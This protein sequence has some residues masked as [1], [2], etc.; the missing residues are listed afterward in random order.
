M[1]TAR[2]NKTGSPSGSPPEP[3]RPDLPHGPSADDRPHS[4]EAEESQNP[5]WRSIPV[6]LAAWHTLI[7][8]TATLVVFIAGYMLLSR[9]VDEQESHLIQQ[10]LHQFR[11]QYDRDGLR[12]VH[13]MCQQRLL[14]TSRTYFVRLLNDSGEQL[15]QRDPQDW[16]G[17][18]LD[19]LPANP[20]PEL[21]WNEV[22]GP[23]DLLLRVASQRTKD[24]VTL[25]VGK[26]LELRDEILGRFR[27][28]WIGIGLFLGAVGAAGGIYAT[29]RAL[30]PVA[31]LTANAQAIMDTGDFSSR[32]KSARTRDELDELVGCF[33][34]MLEKIERL[35][36]GMR[37][38]LD[39][40]AHDLRTPMTRLRHNALRAVEGNLDQPQCIHALGDCLEESDR[41][42]TLLSN[43]M[44]IAEAE[45]GA[46]SFKRQELSLHPLGLKILDLYSDLAEEKQVALHVH[47]PEEL[48]VD[49]EEIRLFRAIANLVDN[50]LKYSGPGGSVRL[51]GSLRSGTVHIEVADQGCGIPQDELPRIWERLYRVDR[52]RDLKGL[53]LGL[54]LVKAIVEAHGG[55]V[56]VVSEF[57][58]GSRFLLQF[59]AASRLAPK[60]AA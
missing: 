49:G 31:Q 25:Q 48:R 12:G 9:W 26:T 14:R 47:L 38:A 27:T 44:D 21:R 43:L 10:R 3:K 36:A 39:N 7:Y 16:D 34:G 50:A 18:P 58:K 54:S 60:P 19:S 53:G 56:G 5:L 35:I 24:G 23:D 8:L 20:K 15:F 59:P 46:L 41:V 22:E 30:A 1:S 52:S 33:N 57:G 32:I 51:T 13:E 55:S 28:A 17:F 4:G 6:R 11:L 40:V 42:L 2:N 45:S 29:R 37:D